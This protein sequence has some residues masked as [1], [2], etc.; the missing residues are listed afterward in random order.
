M[1]FPNKQIDLGFHLSWYIFRL[2]FKPFTIP[3]IC[4][5]TLSK[6]LR[7]TAIA[8]AQVLEVFSLLQFHMR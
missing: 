1:S 2:F 7:S 5:S 3:S 8:V 4:A 6:Y